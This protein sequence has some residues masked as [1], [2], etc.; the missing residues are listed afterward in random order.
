MKINIDAKKVMEMGTSIL[1]KT[2]DISKKTAGVLKESA[3][4]ISEKTKNDSYLRRLKK[5]NPLFLEQYKSEDY[6]IPNMIMIVDDAVRRGID[7][8]EGAIG[9][10]NK[11]KDIEVLYLYDEAVA[12]SGIQFVPTITCDAVYYVDSFNRNRFIRIDCIFNKAHE[13]RLAELKHIAYSLGAKFCSIEISESCVEVTVDKRKLQINEN[14][15]GTRVA[16][17]E[18]TERS[19]SYKG[20]NQRNGRVEVRF[21]GNDTPK[22][23]ELK[24]FAHDENIKRLI[25]IRCK[26]DNYIKSET[27]ELQGASSATM[28]QKTAYA[29][30]SAVSQMGVRGNS[31]MESQATRENLSKLVYYIEF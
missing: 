26:N 5:Y 6:H 2:T 4:T 10:T 8:C 12:V 3:K 29:I 28:S 7:V 30:D 22:K 31:A 23:P 11:E 20:S 16:S 19:S 13:E 25:E 9:W 18:S 21:E 15:N 1:Q 27:L 17:D 14:I 24:W